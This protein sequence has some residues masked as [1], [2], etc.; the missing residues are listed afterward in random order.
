MLRQVCDLM[1]LTLM[2]INA[3]NC[4]CGWSTRAL[5]GRIY[6]RVY[7]RAE[8]DCVPSS[9]NAFMNL[10]PSIITIHVQA[11][12]FLALKEIL[13]GPRT[14]SVACRRGLWIM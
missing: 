14:A 7:I 6:A 13:C 2:H 3:P 8:I 10:F 11:I 9:T 5:V 1:A 12:F 4:S